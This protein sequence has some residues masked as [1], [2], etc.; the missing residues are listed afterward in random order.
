LGSRKQGWDLSPAGAGV[1]VFHDE[2]GEARA[3]ELIFTEEVFPQQK[4][5]GLAD[6]L[7]G[8]PMKS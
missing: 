2:S 5:L 6:Q 7:C 8:K 4:P 1:I 3:K